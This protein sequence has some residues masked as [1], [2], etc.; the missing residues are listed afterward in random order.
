[1][2]I[3]VALTREPPRNDSLADALR[4]RCLV[5]EVALT[6]T[7][8]RSPREVTLELAS[9]ENFGTYVSV[10]LTSARAAS[11]VVTALDGATADASLIVVGP[12]TATSV[13]NGDVDVTAHCI[14]VPDVHSALGVASLIDHGPVLILSAE[15]PR[16]E[17]TDTLRERRVEFDSVVVYSTVE[18]QLSKI[19]QQ[20][21][22]TADI[23]VISAPSAWRVASKFVSVACDV[24]TTG[25]T[26][27]STVQ[28][29]HPNVTNAQ[30][31]EL[32]DVICE[33]IDARRANQS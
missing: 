19:E 7:M 21:L 20:Q 24:V 8:F 33:L 2:T 6:S 26:T 5:T 11:Y 17:L 22:A 4:Q 12:D 25:P 15:N 23:V 13:R 29:E 31:R 30:D 16:A 32:S 28:A 18:R 10:I 14:V 9:L 1:M 3:T 27:L